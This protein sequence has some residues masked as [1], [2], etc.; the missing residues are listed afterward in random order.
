MREF[1]ILIERKDKIIVKIDEDNLDTNLISDYESTMSN[2]GNDKIKKLAENIAYQY[3][4]NF[5]QTYEGIGVIKTDGLDFGK[6]DIVEGIK[7]ETVYTE[8]IEIEVDEW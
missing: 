2:L 5:N 8:D 7:I 3:M 6:E 4:D 1:E